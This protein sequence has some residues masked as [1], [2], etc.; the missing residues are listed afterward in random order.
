MDE[1]LKLPNDD[2]ENS[3]LF[4]FLNHFVWMNN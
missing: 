2:G 1:S 3:S 4:F